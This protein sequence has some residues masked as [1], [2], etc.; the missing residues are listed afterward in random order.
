MQHLQWGCREEECQWLQHQ[1]GQ[2]AWAHN[3]PLYWSPS[4]QSH[5]PTAQSWHPCPSKAA[6]CWR[7]PR[8][9]FEYKGGWQVAAICLETFPRLAS[10]SRTP[11]SRRDG[12]WS[13]PA[14]MTPPSW[15]SLHWLHRSGLTP[16]LQFPGSRLMRPPPVPPRLGFQCLWTSLFVRHPHPPFPLAPDSSPYWNLLQKVRFLVHPPYPQLTPL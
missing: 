7:Q 11:G 9:S 10:K 1:K 2:N 14:M 4:S 8:C 3:P 16:P 12:S 13:S 5:G 15:M 6:V